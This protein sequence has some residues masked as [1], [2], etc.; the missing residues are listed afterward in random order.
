MQEENILQTKI[1]KTSNFVMVC[2]GLLILILGFFISCCLK[3]VNHLEASNKALSEDLM[4]YVSHD[5]SMD[6][7]ANYYIIYQDGRLIGVAEG[8]PAFANLLT[9]KRALNE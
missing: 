7:I 2:M 5:Y 4:K 8:C 9:P 3:E 1:I 6:M